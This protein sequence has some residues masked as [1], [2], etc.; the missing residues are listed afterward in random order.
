[1]KYNP[2]F[3]LADV[4]DG[5]A[6][7]SLISQADKEFEMHMQMDQAC[8]DWA[9]ANGKEVFYRIAEGD[10]RDDIEIVD[11]E[12]MLDIYD[13]LNAMAHIVQG[14]YDVNSFRRA[15]ALPAVDCLFERFITGQLA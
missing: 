14:F 8:V 1:M 12:R 15:L 9:K 6:V 13:P 7:Q 11:L 3:F 10:S 4:Y 5:V 2:T